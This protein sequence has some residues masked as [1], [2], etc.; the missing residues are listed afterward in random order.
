MRFRFP[1]T[2]FKRKAKNGKNIY[3]FRV[4]DDTRHIRVSKSTGCTSLERA[5][6]YVENFLA[7]PEKAAEILNIKNP[8]SQTFK[9]YAE[10]WWLWDKCPYVLARRNRG[11]EKHP[12]IKKSYVATC[13]MWTE[14]RL[15]PFFGNYKLDEITPFLIEEFF[16]I[17]KNRYH[18]SQKTINNV[19][20]V[21]MIMFKEAVNN[22]ILDSNPVEKTLQR[23]VDKKKNGRLT[24][25]EASEI[26]DISKLAYYWKGDLLGYAASYLAAHSGMRLG[27]IIALKI[28]NI[29]ENYIYV[30]ST[31]NQKFG[32]GTTK[33]SEDKIVPITPNTR[34]LLFEVYEKSGSCSGY[35]FSYPNGVPVAEGRLRDPFYRAMRILGISEEDRKERNIQFKSWRNF[36]ITVCQKMNINPA[37]IRAVVGHLTVSM[38]DHYTSF[39]PDEL[40]FI[41]EKESLLLSAPES[42]NKWP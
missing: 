27:E 37:M 11:T 25:E 24:E 33:N 9:K 14:S 22:K 40:S 5:R 3:Y 20:S 10:S 32:I 6:M 13:R 29:H 31:Y 23:T 15:I 17:L 8:K 28:E 38:T 1:Y 7:D 42:K 39:L 41:A 26:L 18:L 21:L 34:N 2:F 30:C 4:W 19:R 12:G 35:I 36:F 16:G